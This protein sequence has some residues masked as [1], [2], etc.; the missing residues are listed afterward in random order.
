MASVLCGPLVLKCWASHEP[1]AAALL[2]IC[3]VA[4][5][6]PAHMDS[7]ENNKV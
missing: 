1:D 4:G 7:I 6:H 5:E 2:F 3:T